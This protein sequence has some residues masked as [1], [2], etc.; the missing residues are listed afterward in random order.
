M[1]KE[2]EPIT[3]RQQRRFFE[4]KDRSLCRRR[5][6]QCGEQAPFHVPNPADSG[7]ITVQ[8][9]SGTDT[10]A[11]DVQAAARFGEYRERRITV[12][13]AP[14]PTIIRSEEHPSELQ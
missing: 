9:P 10:A 12:P 1:L 3:A 2:V 7:S 4:H 8:C 11:P 5:R 13:I 6:C 14:K